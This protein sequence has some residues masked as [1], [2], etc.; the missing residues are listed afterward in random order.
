M[1]FCPK[2]GYQMSNKNAPCPGCGYQNEKVTSNQSAYYQRDS[3]SNYYNQNVNSRQNHYNYY[4]GKYPQVQVDATGVLVWSVINLMCCL[5][6]GI[7]GFA[8][9]LQA[10]YA[11]TQE[12]AENSLKNAKI[13]NIIGTGINLL[14]IFLFI[15]FIFIIGD[16]EAYNI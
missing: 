11:Q 1:F 3:Y 5:P 16:L 15:L 14:L 8:F 4:D 13:F 7:V 10:M 2:C 12:D 6:L 9:T